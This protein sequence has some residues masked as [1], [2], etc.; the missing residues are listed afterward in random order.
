MEDEAIIHLK[1]VDGFK[2]CILTM[3]LPKV[4]INSSLRK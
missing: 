4:N 3:T 1:E 2:G